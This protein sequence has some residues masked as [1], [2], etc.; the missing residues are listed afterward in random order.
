MGKDLTQTRQRATCP[1]SPGQR[2]HRYHLL[3]GFQTWGQRFPTSWSCQEHPAE[4]N[5][6]GSQ[7]KGG[8]AGMD[9]E[10]TLE[11]HLSVRSG[12]T[13]GSQGHAAHTLVNQSQGRG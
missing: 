3:R 1:G 11:S 10:V 4:N 5:P 8:G 13:Q 2:G 9:R 7:R 12:F 6:T